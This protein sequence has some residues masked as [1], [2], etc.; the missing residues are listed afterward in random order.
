M[1]LDIGSEARRWVYILVIY[2]AIV[3]FTQRKELG[4]LEPQ[5]YRVHHSRISGNHPDV[6]GK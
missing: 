1:L 4:S 5:K 3:A 6:R 2:L